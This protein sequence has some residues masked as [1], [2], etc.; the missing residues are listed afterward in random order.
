[1]VSG[2]RKEI[3]DVVD[4]GPHIANLV[5]SANKARPFVA[6]PPAPEPAPRRKSAPTPD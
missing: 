4:L 1:M 2:E 3:G 6:P 5:I